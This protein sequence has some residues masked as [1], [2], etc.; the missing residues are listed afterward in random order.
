MVL[1]RFGSMKFERYKYIP[2]IKERIVI[3]TQL[4]EETEVENV[5]GIQHGN[6]NDYLVIN[7]SSEKYIIERKVFE[8]NYEKCQ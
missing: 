1:D 2:K 6:I 7:N 5:F 4:D 3:A 8:E